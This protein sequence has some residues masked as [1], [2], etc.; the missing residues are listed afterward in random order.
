MVKLVTETLGLW[1]WLWL[2]VR[3]ILPSVP[4]GASTVSLFEGLRLVSSTASVLE[5]SFVVLGM[6]TGAL[7][8]V[9]ALGVSAFEW[10]FS[11]DFG[12]GFRWLAVVGTSLVVGV[13]F[14]LIGRLVW[15]VFYF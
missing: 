10:S 1:L 5:G 13:F 8:D 15:T 4:P 14:L 11:R 9:L 12:V 3:A 7:A 6:S 2:A